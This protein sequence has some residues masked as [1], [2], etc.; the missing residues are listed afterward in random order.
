MSEL[1]V[2]CIPK[3]ELFSDV[4]SGYR[5]ISCI[6]LE[7]PEG[8]TLNKF[9]NFTISG[10][11]IKD[12][13]LN[14]ECNLIIEEMENSKYPA[15]Y[16]LSGF[17][18]VSWDG[19]YVKIDPNSELEILSRLME[20]KQAK[21]VLEAYPDFAQMVLNGETDSIDYNK[22]Y[23]VGKKRL[24]TYIKKIQK[25]CKYILF[26]SVCKK[27]GIIKGD[28]VQK[29]SA[30]Y[31]NPEKFE[32]EFLSDPYVIYHKFLGLKFPKADQNVKSWAKEKYLDSMSRCRACLVYV[33][34]ENEETGDTR[35]DANSAARIV[36][37]L[38]PECFHL[39]KGVVDE[40]S[41]LTEEENLG[42]RSFYYDP[43][44]K[45]L[46]LYY[47][48][49]AEKTI[50]E[51]IIQRVEDKSQ[52]GSTEMNWKKFRTIGEQTCTDEQMEILKKIAEG[53]RAV[54]LN[55]PAGVGKSFTLKSII[56]M[57]EDNHYSYQ[58]L[59]PTGIAAKRMSES[60]GR[61]AMTIHRFLASCFNGSPDID[62][63]IIDE[64]SMV[65]VN[66]MATFFN[67]ILPQANIVFICD[68]AQLASIGGG[69]IVQDLIDTK[70]LPVV[71]LTKVFRYGVGGIATIS[72][73]CRLGTFEH[74]NDSFPDYK[75]I[76]IDNNLSPIDA[77]EEI[78]I[79]LV[80]HQG[81]N[82][83]D[84]MIL[85]PM[86]IGEM[87]TNFINVV[88][89]NY[90][91]EKGKV[92]ETPMSYTVTKSPVNEIHFCIGDKVINTKNDYRM[93]GIEYDEDYEEHYAEYPIMNGDIGYVRD[94]RVNNGLAELI[95]EFDVGFVVY[96]GNN[97]HYLSLAYATTVHK[98]QG[99]QAKAIIFVAN[100]YHK[101]MLTR[102]LLYVA[103]SRA[104]KQLIT[105]VEDDVINDALQIQ[106]N[107]ERNTW[108][109]DLLKK[110]DI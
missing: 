75:K 81:Y 100:D 7:K 34:E 38:T 92:K 22:I 110:E 33:L 56:T 104:Q 39:I 94:Y 99:A 68:E 9:N 27:Y 11:N 107:K 48:Y 67:V 29:I 10:Y 47:T 52:I 80:E 77:I 42:T 58:L 49:I 45:M 5:T 84:I 51:N 30:I 8:L 103:F 106:E 57:L 24:A 14:Q 55:G 87:G 60:T 96:R 73:D 31:S 90:Y 59:A 66:L 72:T 16:M 50:A 35:I 36:H 109:K 19:R 54:M 20:T 83:D 91:L 53:N 15:S 65:S 101:K 25:D 44:N 76:S 69:N 70:T 2:R 97:I 78:Y 3:K 95:V 21:Y 17:P 102:N 61:S 82:K 85:S 64:T 26:F 18:G 41:K 88:I 93:E 108:L 63:F 105:I 79:D 86:R 62:Y 32:E 74:S 71:N 89:Q 1:T 46:S 13:P 23:N 40:D 98:I 12:I 6:P 4:L 37:Q 28:Q 43:E